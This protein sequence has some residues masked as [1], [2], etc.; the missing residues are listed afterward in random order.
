MRPY[1]RFEKVTTRSELMK[2]RALRR[3]ERKE[4]D[5]MLVSEYLS[6]PTVSL[7]DLARKYH[8]QPRTIL[9]RRGIE[10]RRLHRTHQQILDIEQAIIDEYSSDPTVS[11]KELTIKYSLHAPSVLDKYGISRKKRKNRERTC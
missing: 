5:E 7:R 2:E 11:L 6:D 4:R 9:E 8:C 1:K 10:I 3:E